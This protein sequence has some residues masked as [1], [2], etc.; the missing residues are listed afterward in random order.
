MTEVYAGWTERFHL[1]P[2]GMRAG[3]L[4]V[5][6]PDPLFPRDVTFALPQGRYKKTPKKTGEYL[7]LV[8]Q[9]VP[10]GDAWV[11][12]SPVNQYEDPGMDRIFADIDSPDLEAGLQMARRYEDWCMTHFGV[13][14]PAIFTAGKGFHLQFTFD[15]VDVPGLGAEPGA[16]TAFSDAF[17]GLI[18]GSGATLDPQP[19]KHRYASPRIPY[20]LRL[21]A[22]G[23]YQRPMFV[24]PVD[25]TWSLKEILRASAQ[26]NVM[27][28]EVPHSTILGGLLQPQVAKA[29]KALQRTKALPQHV[30]KGMREDLV[31]AAISFSEEV[32]WKLVN[33]HGKPDGRR[34]VLSALYIPAL[35]VETNADRE[36]VLKSCEAWV[37]LAGARWRDYQRFVEGAIKDCILKDGTLRHPVGM[38]RFWAEIQDLRVQ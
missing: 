1:E 15:F 13:Q 28:F 9:N 32:G 36:Q 22:T 20:S 34:R 38:R 2:K 29:S 25:L 4:A 37:G 30:L 7:A 5:L 8:E 26:I 23:R 12:W 27:S 35:M 19:L 10:K 18:Q 14:P 21:E 3:W 24:V 33:A 11:A 31:Q 6:G 16:G 17:L